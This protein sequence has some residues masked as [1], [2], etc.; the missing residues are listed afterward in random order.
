[1][2]TK[3]IGNESEL[4]LLFKELL[5]GVRDDIEETQRNVSL[6]YDAIQVEGGKELYGTIY[7]EALKIKGSARDRQLKFL[8]MF[9]ER[10]SKK[11][12]MLVAKKEENSEDSFDNFSQK[13]MILAIEE[14]KKNE[15]KD[16][17]KPSI[18]LEKSNKISPIVNPTFQVQN[19]EEEEDEN[20]DEEEEN[21]KE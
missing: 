4:N 10:V 13:D 14:M 12:A 6:Y 5:D 11:E 20:W 21:E 7:N 3:I 16:L 15:K 18:V 19:D 1:M 8:N 17:V 9:K 2:E